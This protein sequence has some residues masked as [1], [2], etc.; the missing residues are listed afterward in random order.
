MCCSIKL[1]AQNLPN[2]LNFT[3]FQGVQYAQINNVWHQYIAV[4]ERFEWVDNNII[5]VKFKPDVS[6]GKLNAFATQFGLEYAN[7]TKAGWYDYKLNGVSLFPLASALKAD[8]RVAHVVINQKITWHTTVPNDPNLATS[9]IPLPYGEGWESYTTYLERIK[10]YDAIDVMQNGAEG[11]CN[12]SAIIAILDNE[13][14]Y[15]LPELYTAAT[16]TVAEQTNIYYNAADPWPTKNDPSSTTF[17]F[18][19]NDINGYEDD[20]IGW[21]FAGNAPCGAGTPDLDVKNIDPTISSIGHGTPIAHIIG[22]RQNN[23]AGM[24][25]IAGGWND[26]DGAKMM[27][28]KVADIGQCPWSSVYIKYGLEYARTNGAKIVSMSFG[29]DQ[30][31]QPI[32]DELYLCNK[33]QGMFL[34]ASAGNKDS[35]DI[36]S[37]SDMRYPA[38]SEHVFTVGASDPPNPSIPSATDRPWNFNKYINANYGLQ[39]LAPGGGFWIGTYDRLG[40]KTAMGGTSASAPMVAATAANM[41]CMNPCLTNFKI[42]EL[43]R[44]SAT[45]VHATLTGGN[46][47]DY[48]GFTANYPQTCSHGQSKEYGFGLLNE[49]GALLAAQAEP[50]VPFDLYIKDCADDMG[51]EYT[52]A[53]P[54]AYACSTVT[55][56]SPDIWIR[57]NDD[58]LYK[59]ENEGALHNNDNWIYVRVRNRSCTPYIASTDDGVVNLYWSVAASYGSWPANWDGSTPSIGGLL[60]SITLPNIPAGGSVVLKLSMPKASW[61]SV[62]GANTHFCVMARLEKLNND[63]DPPFTLV[64]NLEAP[65]NNCALLNTM[66]FGAAPP[67]KMPPTLSNV[68]GTTLDNAAGYDI[69]IGNPRPNSAIFNFTFEELSVGDFSLLNDAEIRIAFDQQAWNAFQNSAAMNSTN[70]RILSPRVIKILNNKVTFSNVQLPANARYSI[71]VSIN[72]NTEAEV[73]RKY[74]YRVTQRCT[75]ANIDDGAMNFEIVSGERPRFDANAGPDKV[76][77]NSDAIAISATDI[78][79]PARY[80][81]TNE[82]GQ[83]V[84][85]GREFTSSF[86]KSELLTVTATSTSDGYKSTDEMQVQ[87]ANATINGIY[88]N[89]V[90]DAQSFTASIS[91]TM[92]GNK[93]LLITN[94][95][96]YYSFN[97]PS[98]AGTHAVTCS[99]PSPGVYTAVLICNGTIT[100]TETLLIQ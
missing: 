10:H 37:T 21:D 90:T 26:I 46:F 19:D 93:S 81:W 56:K 35:K 78:G 82:A 29:Y 74:E 63:V 92:F 68:F 73:Y 34:V 42:A 7:N 44:N 45:Q 53:K 36:K 67:K 95:Q 31:D 51:I 9:P 47:A 91:T 62:L 15:T 65:F 20:N 69:K 79:E 64:Y 59:Q 38:L 6:T 23:G 94:G 76:A 72:M 18:D 80:I 87:Y 24:A 43:L 70:V 52:T 41:L 57:R 75:E 88:P 25:G 61:P 98:E 55:D 66:M 83:I 89:P 50:Y 99:L 1:S 14:N 54:L 96:N 4:E 13:F 28:I 33:V 84:H 22:A 3:T 48:G 39:L 60:G 2:A 11:W 100:D 27:F 40:G 16:G 97:V 49:H 71:F 12:H 77:F 5:S 17:P 8:S 85:D 32:E 30:F 86:S 58:G